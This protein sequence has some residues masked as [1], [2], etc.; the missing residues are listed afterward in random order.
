MKILRRRSTA[1]GRLLKVTRARTQLTCRA[2]EC[3]IYIFTRL[4][5]LRVNCDK[6]DK[7]HRTSCDNL[8]YTYKCIIYTYVYIICNLISMLCWRQICKENSNLFLSFNAQYTKLSQIRLVRAVSC[9][10]IVFKMELTK[11]FKI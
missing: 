3:L 8:I 9:N 5:W 7:I 2:N 1:R 10:I 6:T 11:M 4:V